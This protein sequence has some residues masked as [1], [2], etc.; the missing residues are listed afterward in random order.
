MARKPDIE[1]QKRQLEAAV[2]AACARIATQSSK[3]VRQVRLNAER[4]EAEGLV[5]ACDAELALRGDHEFTAEEATAALEVA[6]ALPEAALGERIVAAFQ[7]VPARDYEEELVRVIDANPGANYAAIHKEFSRK[8]TALV[9]GHLV[10]DRFG[11]FRSL[12]ATEEDRTS[13]LLIKVAKG[14]QVTWQLK[15]EAQAAFA[16]LGVLAAA[17]A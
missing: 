3:D 17:N 13:L 14:K 10:Y 5:A 2:E 15:P 7:A 12:I 16:S 8:D 1:A 4:K 9:A 6:S 11:Y